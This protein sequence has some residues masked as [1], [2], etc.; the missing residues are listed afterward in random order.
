MPNS[1]W[2]TIGL[3]DSRKSTTASR[4][5]CTLAHSPGAGGGTT[6]TADTRSS[7]FALRSVVTTEPMVAR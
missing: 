2:A 5:S 4:I 6:T 1:R 7:T 3:P